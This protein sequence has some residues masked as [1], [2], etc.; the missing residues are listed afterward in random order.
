MRQTVRRPR[1]QSSI[2]RSAER[3]IQCSIPDVTLIE[4]DAGDATQDRTLH[5]VPRL[6]P[7]AGR[8]LR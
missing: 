2:R 1:I 8:G 7:L 3:A 4:I 6:A 5:K